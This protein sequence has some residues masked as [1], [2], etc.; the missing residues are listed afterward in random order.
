MH[1]RFLNDTDVFALLIFIIVRGSVDHRFLVI[2]KKRGSGKKVDKTDRVAHH[3]E[4]RQL[5]SIL[6]CFM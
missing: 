5:H 3:Q 1:L 4:K 6:R 2:A